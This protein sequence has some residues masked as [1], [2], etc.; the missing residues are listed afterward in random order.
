MYIF[1]STSL[2]LGSTAINMIEALLPGQWREWLCCPI[3]ASLPQ[4]SQSTGTVGVAL[5][6]QPYN[7]GALDLHFMLKSVKA[8]TYL[9]SQRANNHIFNLKI[10]LWDLKKYRHKNTSPLYAV[11][12]IPFLKPKFTFFNLPWKL[13]LAGSSLK[14]DIFFNEIFHLVLWESLDES[15]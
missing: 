12:S 6:I 5:H 7:S 1:S 9:G 11:K 15:L 2:L 8:W 13:Q 3:A 10:H 4:S 14:I